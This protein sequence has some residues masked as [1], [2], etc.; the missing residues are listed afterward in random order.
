MSSED[1]TFKKREFSILV[2][3]LE[4][5]LGFLPKNKKLLKDVFIYSFYHTKKKTLNK[6]YFLDFQRLEF[7][8]DA[9]L[10]S[11]ISHFL[12]E[13]FPEKKEGELTK[14]RSQIVCRRKLNEISKK[15]TLTEVIFQKNQSIISDNILGNTLE[16][17]I[18]YIYLEIGY[19]GCQKFVYNKI[20]NYHVNISKLQKEIFS[21]KVWVIEWSQKNKFILKFN[22]FRDEKKTKNEEENKHLITYF[23]E[24]TIYQYGIKTIGRGLSKKNSEEM[25]AKNAYFIIQKKSKKNTEL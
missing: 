9:V 11:I 12:C 16:A 17:L 23:S 6:N 19:K 15:M 25:A 10:N 8:G 1:T 4:K 18:G 3:R 21:Y 13:K 14:V 7:L 22:T 2:S 5:I 20:L 24:M